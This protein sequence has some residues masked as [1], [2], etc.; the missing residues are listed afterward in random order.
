ME[1]NRVYSVQVLAGD[2]AS[3]A[4]DSPAQIEK[5]LWEFLHGFRVGGEFIYRDRLR[6]SLLLGKHT[7]DVNLNDLL[8]FNQEL[9]QL[10]MERPG[11]CVPLVR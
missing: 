4:P 8:L 7:L 1:S 2:A 10:F 5:A 6:S 3:R 11:E 9:G